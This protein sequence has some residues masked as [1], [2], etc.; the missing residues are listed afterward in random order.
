MTM[1]WQP[2][3]MTCT[4][5]CIPFRPS[6][7][8]RI[9]WIWADLATMHRIN[10]KHCGVCLCVCVCVSW[11]PA[12]SGPVMRNRSS[13]YGP[14]APAPRRTRLYRT[15]L[16][17]PRPLRPRGSGASLRSVAPSPKRT[18]SRSVM[19]PRSAFPVR[20]RVHIA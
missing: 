17:L 8:H 3:D 13:T 1:D 2:Q 18:L 12:G 16:Y 5:G 7:T 20:Q 19:T 9:G 10:M 14:L 15:R 4:S 11:T 6:N